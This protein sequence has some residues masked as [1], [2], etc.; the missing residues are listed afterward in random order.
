MISAVIEFNVNVSVRRTDQ[1]LFTS[2]IVCVNLDR[3]ILEYDVDLLRK[4]ASIPHQDHQMPGAD[5]MSP[6]INRPVIVVE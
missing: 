6:D 3:V 4:Y 2:Y 5:V 1:V